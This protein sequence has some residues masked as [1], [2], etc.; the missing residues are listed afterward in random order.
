M[1]DLIGER[2]FG[3]VIIDLSPSWIDLTAHEML[4]QLDVVHLFAGCFSNA[5]CAVSFTGVAE[6]EDLADTASSPTSVEHSAQSAS[7]AVVAF[8]GGL[9]VELRWFALE[10][11]VPR[12]LVSVFVGHGLFPSGWVE[13]GRE[14]T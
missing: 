13:M 7:V 1:L 4:V 6:E 10:R 9:I 12:T 5:E 14:L 11:A 8:I 2:V 3:K